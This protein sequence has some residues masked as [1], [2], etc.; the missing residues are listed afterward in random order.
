MLTAETDVTLSG[1]FKTKFTKNG[2]K[3][4]ILSMMRKI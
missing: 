1:N 3:F 2:K 4:L